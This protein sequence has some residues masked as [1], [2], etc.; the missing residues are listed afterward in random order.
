MVSSSGL[1]SGSLD[2]VG[3]MIDR[4]LPSAAMI[5]SGGAF[6]RSIS[7]FILAAWC[8]AI[9]PPR[10]IT[11][12]R[13]LMKGPTSTAI[14]NRCANPA[15]APKQINLMVGLVINDGEGGG[16]TSQPSV[17]REGAN[18]SAHPREFP[19]KS[20]TLIVNIMSIRGRKP[21]PNALK[22]LQGNPGKRPMNKHEP[23][24][25]SSVKKPRGMGK[26]AKKFWS[27]HAPEMERLQ[28]LTGIDSAAFQLMAEHYAIAVQ[29]AQELHKGGLTVKGKDGVKKN[30][31]AQVFKDNALAFK[32]FATEFGMTPSSRTRLKVPEEAEQLTLAEQLFKMVTVVA[33]EEAEA[34]VGD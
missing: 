24:P 26:G 1:G 29:A 3:R 2:S 25:K 18:L 7:A 17:D 12:Y 22:N 34:S 13:L 19:K 8:A 11:S 23:K 33:E 31:L 28:V 15:I 9:R 4:P 27:Q 32:A 30:P 10:S 6:E 5:A 20:E 21:K 14:C 16:K